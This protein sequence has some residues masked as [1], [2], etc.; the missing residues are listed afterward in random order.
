MCRRRCP[1][2]PL[3]AAVA[4]VMADEAGPSLKPVDQAALAEADAKFERGIQC[5]RVRSN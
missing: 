5:I 1:P 2:P 4:G 3:P